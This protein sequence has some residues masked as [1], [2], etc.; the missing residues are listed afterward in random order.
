MT[1]VEAD[2]EARRP[3]RA[4]AIPAPRRETLALFAFFALVG[5]F[6]VWIV[7]TSLPGF[8]FDRLHS[9]PYGWLGDALAHGQLNLRYPEVPQGFRDLPDPFDPRATFSYRWEQHLHDL[10][11][12]DGKLYIYWGVVPALLLFAPLRLAGIWM[13]QGLAVIIL[14]FGGLVFSVLTLRFLVRRF[15]PRTPTWALWVG[16]LTLAFG[17]AVPFM[18]RRPEHSEVAIGGG[19]CFGFLAVWLLLSGW[20]GP[21]MSLRR[22]CGASLAAGLAVGSRPTWVII[23][24]VPAVM[25][26][27][28]WR[29]GREERARIGLALVAPLAICGSLLMAYNVAR[30]GSPLELGSKYQLAGYRQNQYAAYTPAYLA[31]GLFFYLLEPPHL[32]PLFPFFALGPPP[33]YPGTLPN[34]YVPFGEPTAGVL[35]TAPIVLLL[36]LLP[37][38]VGRWGS[39]LRRVVPTFVAIA[40]AMALMI[41]GALWSTTERYVIDFTSFLLIAALMVWFTGLTSQRRRWRQVSLIA[42]GAALCWGG[43]L[44]AALSFTGYA[45]SL[46]VTQPKLWSGLESTF[47]PVSRVLAGIAG[48]P[49]IGR[50][51]PPDLQPSTT[52]KWA[53]LGRDPVELR[54]GF[55]PVSLRVVSPHAGTYHLHATVEPGPDIPAGTTVSLRAATRQRQTDVVIR[56]GA[57]RVLLPVRLDRGVT[58]VTVMARAQ[59]AAGAR[60]LAVADLG[61]DKP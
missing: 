38:A 12:N 50:I 53:S 19:L 61:F 21:T 30:F 9:G 5:A 26:I 13:Y 41:S 8:R 27:I 45:P 17:N 36:V 39:A 11:Y 58:T 60:V 18:L 59:R 32:T 3:R 16:Q 14:C 22:L 2:V 43:L 49:V 40:I 56:G 29:S 55:S 20:Y 31:P 4:H 15:L 28:A 24:I 42:G 10:S 57:T 35:P 25:A 44:G 51:S 23:A 7:W 52:Q 48:R 46:V 54:L 1:S 33:S 37:L 34:G 47:S 6:Y